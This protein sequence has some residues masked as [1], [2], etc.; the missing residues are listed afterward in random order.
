MISY[1]EIGRQDEKTLRGDDSGNFFWCN[2]H[3]V[4]A[5]VF[6]VLTCLSLYLFSIFVFVYVYYF[7]FSLLFLWAFGLGLF[8]RMDVCSNRKDMRMAVLATNRFSELRPW[9]L[10][11]I[12]CTR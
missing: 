7:R 1:C 3:K 8:S 9:W 11:S 5:I 10:L 6:A 2:G 12:S 4:V